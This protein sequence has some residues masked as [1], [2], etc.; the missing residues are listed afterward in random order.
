[1]KHE[2]LILTAVVIA[3]I[4]LER[5]SISKFSVLIA[6]IRIGSTVG[7]TLSALSWEGIENRIK[8]DKTL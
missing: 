1:M 8:S 4:Q 5:I 2:G 3:N 7:Y 6:T